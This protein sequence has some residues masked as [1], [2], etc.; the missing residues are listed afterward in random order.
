MALI[1]KASAQLTDVGEI[2]RNFTIPNHETGQLL[3]LADY[4]GSIIVLDFFAWWCPPCVRSSPDVEQNIQEYYRL[5]GGNPS[6]L[7]VTVISINVESEVPENTDEFI[8]NG[9]LELVA[10]DFD[11]MAWG[12][13]NSEDGIPLFVV[14]NGAGNAT[15]HKQWEVLHR[16]PGYPGAA[17]LRSIIDSV[18]AR[19]PDAPPITFVDPRIEAAVRSELSLPA[20]V[21]IT[22]SDMQALW[23]LNLQ[24]SGITS[25]SDLQS[26]TELE[27]LDVSGNQIRD[28]RP[29]TGLRKL[30]SLR[31][32]DNPISNFSV[33]ASLTQLNSLSI[34]RTRPSD[35][36][37]LRSLQE[38]VELDLSNTGFRD[39]SLL[40]NLRGLFSL[41]LSRNPLHDCRM[42]SY[43]PELTWLSLAGSGLEQVPA[44]GLSK[45]I[46][47]LDLSHNGLRTLDGIEEYALKHLYVDHNQLTDLFPLFDVLEVSYVSCR[48][49]RLDMSA[50]SP[51]LEDIQIL[52]KRGVRI[53]YLPQ[54]SDLMVIPLGR[55][56]AG[57]HLRVHCVAGQSFYLHSSPDLKEWTTISMTEPSH[58]VIDLIDSSAAA[59]SNRFYRAIVAE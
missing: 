4:A 54:A 32:N 45:N 35:F 7:P 39:L 12:Q 29:L 18:R 44:P 11:G 49:N 34:A 33:L 24:N 46:S 28:L 53:D 23:D 59:Y 19:D 8:A 40:S 52:E 2:A 21:P 30:I 36:S 3:S 50:S 42:L 26:A 15:T 41:N 22:A 5:E 10:D 37:W 14:I 38:L 6:K 20:A 25:L 57:F 16:A 48:R 9:G 58:D 1:V 56:D 31:L 55:S 27:S 51:T 43:W 47:T 17:Y 13:F